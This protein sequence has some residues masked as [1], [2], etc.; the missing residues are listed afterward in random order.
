MAAIIPSPA[1]RTH[2]RRFFPAGGSGRS[3]MA[4]TM[5]IREVR[6]EATK[7]TARVRRV[8]EAKAATSVGAFSE[9]EYCQL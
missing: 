6:R 8:P 3:R 2:G 4:A 1:L 7:I 9:K 5:V